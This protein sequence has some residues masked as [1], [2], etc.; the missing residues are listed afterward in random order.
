[1]AYS[2]IVKSA[3]F[4]SLLAFTIFGVYAIPSLCEGRIYISG[5]TPSSAYPNDVA[6]AYGSGATPNGAVVAVLG[7]LANSTEFVTNATLGPVVG[8]SNVTLGWAFSGESG[9]WEMSFLTPNILPGYYNFYVV[10]NESLNSD[11]TSFQVLMRTIGMPGIGESNG[12]YMLLPGSNITVWYPGMNTSLPSGF[13]LFFVSGA[14]APS[15]GP[16]GT[17]VTMLGRSA[18]GGEITVYFDNQQIAALANQYGDWN[19]SFQVPDVLVGNHTIRAIDV[20]GHWMTTAQFYVTST[21]MNL[22]TSLL[23]LFALLVVIVFLSAVFLML[24]ALS[25]RIRKRQKKL[26]RQPADNC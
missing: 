15:Y 7:G 13:L 5:I 11:V 22:S 2:S 20:N 26:S 1:M 8:S 4:C 3:F 14:V 19:S 24:I 21:V 25:D 10:D 9:D 18:S 23:L 6:H 16:P 12:T 17:L